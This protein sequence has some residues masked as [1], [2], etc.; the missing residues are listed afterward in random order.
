MDNQKLD[1]EEFEKLVEQIKMENPKI[2]IEL[3]KYIAGSYLLYDVMKIERPADN[4]AEV[5]NTVE[6]EA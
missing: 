3:C 2:D 1:P 5:S 6:V 4:I